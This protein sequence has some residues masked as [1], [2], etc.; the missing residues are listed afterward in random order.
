MLKYQMCVCLLFYFYYLFSPLLPP[1]L[2]PPPR[3]NISKNI[4]W[5]EA[6]TLLL[7]LLTFIYSIGKCTLLLVSKLDTHF[8]ERF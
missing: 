4:C 8:S 7:P 2:P 5:L 6:H 3:R 1:P